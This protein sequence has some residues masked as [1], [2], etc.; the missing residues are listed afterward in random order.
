MLSEAIMRKRNLIAGV[1]FVAAF[2]AMQGCSYE[3]DLV[4]TNLRGVVHI[5]AESTRRDVLDIDGNLQTVGPDIRGLGPVYLG[6]Y[7]SIT[8]AGQ[9]ERYPYPEIGPQF[10]QG[11]PGDAYPYGGTTLGDLRFAC[12]QSLACKV[13]S[14]RFLDFDLLLDWYETI[15][16]VVTDVN[17]DPVANGEFI[18]QT[19]FDIF[20]VNTDREAQV[21]AYDKNEDGKVDELDLDFVYDVQ[22]DEFVGQFLIR[23][24]ELF[25]DQNATKDC[26]PGR[27]CRAQSVWGWMDTPA[28]ETYA[29]KTCDPDEGYQFPQYNQQFIGGR[30]FQDVLNQPTKYIEAG[31]YAA[32]EGF[33]WKNVYDEPDIYLDF[34]VQ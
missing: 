9:L 5:P 3:E 1:Q 21:V 27:D 29:Y 23:Q 28:L 26:V 30:A 24:Q 16:V 34:L 33:E 8:P 22:A 13:T 2:L 25:Y 4:I 14:G 18:R 7:A 12:L 11:V 6:L 15:G 20:N 32:G 17:D 10:Q 19:C 31:D